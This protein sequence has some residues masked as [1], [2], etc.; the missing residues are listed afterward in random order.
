[1]D[2]PEERKLTLWRQ[3]RL[4]FRRPRQP[5]SLG[6][7]GAVGKYRAV[8]IAVAALGV[9]AAALRQRFEKRGL[10]AA[11]LADE[12]RDPTAKCQVDPMRER[13]DVERVA[14]WVGFLG[15]DRDPVKERRTPP[16]A[17]T[18]PSSAWSSSFRICHSWR[19]HHRERQRQ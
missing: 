5:K 8:M 11:I 10:P 14:G 18:V 6:Q 2:D 1:M 3:G 9:E 12:E 17:P 15:K 7:G 4:G 16:C 19:A 13:A